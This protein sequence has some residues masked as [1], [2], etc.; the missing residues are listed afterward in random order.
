MI[1]TSNNIKH[2]IYSE[3]GY[4]HTQMRQR[5]DLQKQA[6]GD[7]I[8]AKEM[9]QYLRMFKTIG[10]QEANNTGIQ[11]IL[12]QE[13]MQEIIVEIGR[14]LGIGSYNLFKNQHRWY[15]D[16]QQRWGAD[17]VFEAELA[18]LLQVAGE[19]AV[20][21]SNVN[22][23][24]EII[25][26]LPGNIAK[27][28]FQELSVSGQNA[29]LKSSKESNIINSPY[30]RAIKADVSGYSADFQI[31]STLAPQWEYF[32]NLFSGAK[33]TVKNYSSASSYEIIHLGNTNLFKA[34]L[35]TLYNIGLSSK[36]AMH[37][38]Y[39]AMANKYQNNPKVKEHLQHLRFAYELTGGGLYDSQGNKLDEADFFVYNDP[40]SNNIWV[41]STKEMISNIINYTGGTEG[42]L[43][44][45]VVVLKNAFN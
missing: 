37:V 39:H 8:K 20:G 2:T 21:K 1:Y 23:G 19:K 35:A 17:D 28:F 38:Y 10:N 9:E 34:I 26:N 42:S 27:E 6:Q 11:S 22:T 4:I 43:H 30:F 33:F 7:I 29:I 32:I 3:M 36:E 24:V 12:E 15:L 41:R 31:S 18:T 5:Y 45:G 44:S 14:R 25:G 16:A 40:S 13:G